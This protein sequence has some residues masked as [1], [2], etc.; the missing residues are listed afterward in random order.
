MPNI[1]KLRTLLEY[2]EK[3]DPELIHMSAFKCGT[4][5]CLMGHAV[6]VFPGRFEWQQKYA[7]LFPVDV[8]HPTENPCGSAFFGLNEEEW[9]AIFDGEI[10]DEEAVPN[11][12]QKIEEWE[13]AEH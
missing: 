6:D 4:T 7:T 12:R 5:A 9:D 3:L 11:L 2:V 10:P 8:E 13:D 1:A